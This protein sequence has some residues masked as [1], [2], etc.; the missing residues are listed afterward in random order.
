MNEAVYN[1]F[2]KT[3]VQREGIITNPDAVVHKYR[4]KINKL[5]EAVQNHF[6]ARSQVEKF[7]SQI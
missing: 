2:A 4:Q 5:Y 6:V 3:W 1:K 7:G